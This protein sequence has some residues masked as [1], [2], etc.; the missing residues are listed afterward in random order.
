[1]NALSPIPNF[2]ELER[3]LRL[4]EASRG[5]QGLVRVSTLATVRAGGHDYPIHGL[6]LG[7]DDKSLP[8]LGIMGGVHGLERVGTHLVLAYFDS[9][10]EQ[11][12]WDKDLQDKLRQTRIVSIPLVN[13]AGMHIGKR[14]NAN[15]V[16]LMRNAPV[17][18]SMK[19]AF[20]LGGHRF[21]KSLPW[22]RGPEGQAMEVEAQALCDFVRSE[23]FPA[24]NSLVLDMHSG[25]GSDDRLW[26]PY[27]RTTAPFP[28]LRQVEKLSNLLNLSFPNHVYK[29]EPQSLSY[30]THG[31][32]W[33]YLFDEHYK[34]HGPD[35]PVFIP[36]TLEM[37]SWIWVR[38][39]PLQLFSALGPFNPIKAH[40]HKRTMRRHL[41][42]V[43]FFFRAVKN[44]EAWA[45]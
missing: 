13:P 4:V 1:M 15:G 6:V 25:F 27:A 3:V 44:Y 42:L 33:D 21:S 12:L 32:L 11:L 7:P 5:L 37:G 10:F 22:Y 9:L 23:I 31:D 26:Y 17:E 39:N 43:D 30:T 29:V 41:P 16:D 35:G 34:Q 36:W 45:K 38:K 28:R 14:A 8:T 20:L 18:A 19:P 40:R 2:P 24:R